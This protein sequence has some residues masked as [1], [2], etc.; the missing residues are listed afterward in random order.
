MERVE[1]VGGGRGEG[2]KVGRGCGSV[3][4]WGILALGFGRR[5]LRCAL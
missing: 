2:G 5:V 1:E 4:G 3:S